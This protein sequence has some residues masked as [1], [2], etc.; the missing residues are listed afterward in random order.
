MSITPRFLLALAALA[1]L[2]ACGGGSDTA[3]ATATKS[4]SLDFD[5]VTGTTPVRCGTPVTGLG[6]AST[7]ALVQDL[8]FYI[9]AVKLIKADGSREAVTLDAN[10]WQL[11]RNSDDVALID[12]EDASA[13]C[14]N[15]G[16]GSAGTHAVVTGKVAEG[17]YTGVEFTF[18]VPFALNHTDVTAAPAP[19]NLEAMAWNWQFGR[20]Y[21]VI[22]VKE[23]TTGA[24]GSPAFYTHVGATGCTGNPAT[25]ETANCIRN[26]RALVTLA[27]FDSSTQKIALDLKELLKGENITA[28]TAQTAPGCM[29]STDDPECDSLFAALGLD[30]STGAST[31]TGTAFKALAK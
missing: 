9:H 26:N 24:W 20:R 13:E 15:E 3:T 14:A 19:L 27:S 23:P 31:G 12:L 11:T 18:G 5:I 16:Y 25:G 22:E 21:S 4:V 10:E 7:T 30:L 29:S 6:T 1:A 28:N 8:R 2:S 17:S